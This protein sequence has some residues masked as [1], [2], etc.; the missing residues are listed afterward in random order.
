MIPLAIDPEH[1]ALALIGRGES[2]LRRL[3]GLLEGGATRLTVFS[4]ASD[5]AL[6]RLGGARLRRYLPQMEDLTGTRLVWIAGLPERTA[7]RMA[8]TARA[9]GALV[10][11]EDVRAACDFHNVAQVRRGDLLLTA[12]T[13]GKSPG[14]AARV[15]AVLERQF[16]PEW[17]DRLNTLALDRARWQAEG[18]PTAALARATAARIDAEGWLG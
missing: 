2:V 17:A 16:G 11:V 8:G 3:E 1:V 4:D 5:P 14:L 15:R 10:N 12:S 6:V 7:D 18:R 13:G 9:A